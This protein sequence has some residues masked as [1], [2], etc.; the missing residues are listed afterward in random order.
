MN[1][2]VQVP[3]DQ[4]YLLDTLVDELDLGSRVENVVM[5]PFDG[6]TMVQVLIPVSTATVSVIRK[7]IDA[8]QKARSSYRIFC[9]G[10]ELT[11]FSAREA[12]RF[13]VHLAETSRSEDDDR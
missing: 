4:A 9:R 5:R 6:L 1:I 12:E 13:I 3:E 10:M 11:G 2:S 7:W 8:R